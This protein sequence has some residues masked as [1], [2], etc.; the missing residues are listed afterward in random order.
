MHLLQLGYTLGTLRLVSEWCTN[1]FPLIIYDQWDTE[2]FVQDYG[3]C[4]FLEVE[5]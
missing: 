3:L 1:L 2:Y 5:I 4:L